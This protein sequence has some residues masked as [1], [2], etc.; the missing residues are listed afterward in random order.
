MTDNIPIHGFE[1][2]LQTGKGKRIFKSI[3]D[4]NNPNENKKNCLWWTYH[5]GS[6]SGEISMTKEVADIFKELSE[7]PS[8][9]L[10]VYL[11]NRIKYIL[12]NKKDYTIHHV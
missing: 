8:Y 12:D 5:A 9:R 11:R 2:W 7:L 1:K 4:R 10:P 6:A 3:T